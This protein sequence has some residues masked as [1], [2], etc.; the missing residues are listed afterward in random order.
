MN[1]VINNL[2]TPNNGVFTFEQHFVIFEQH[3][4]TL[5]AFIIICCDF[6]GV[7]LW[8]SIVQKE[9]IQALI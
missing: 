7:K 9:L 2:C 4:I 6:K 5:N 3:F 1:I 8:S